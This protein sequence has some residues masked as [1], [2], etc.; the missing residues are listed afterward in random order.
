MTQPSHTIATQIADLLLER[1]LRPQ[2]FEN[3]AGKQA[4]VSP[5]GQLCRL[6]IE[7]EHQR[8]R[9]MFEPRDSGSAEEPTEE[10]IELND[11]HSADCIDNPCLDCRDSDNQLNAARR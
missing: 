7:Y 9:E 1:E 10:P 11:E 2:I 4:A 6:L 5:W 3:G 8:T